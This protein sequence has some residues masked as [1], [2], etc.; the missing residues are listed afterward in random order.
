MNLHLPPIFQLPTRLQPEE[1]HELEG[2]IDS[3]TYNIHE[4]DIVLGNISR[5]ERAI[6]ELRRARLETIPLCKQVT[7]V[8]HTDQ[9]HDTASLVVL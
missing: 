6:F 2:K 8:P 3:L 7:A 4:A 5:R 9:L 1:L